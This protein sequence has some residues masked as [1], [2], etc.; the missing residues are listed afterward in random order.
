M[1]IQ[2]IGNNNNKN[3]IG[4]KVELISKDKKQFKEQ[5]PTRGYQ[6]SS[7]PILHFGLG[8]TRTIDTLLV[9]WPDG[10][11][12]FNYHVV[13]N[14]KIII[15]KNDAVSL[16]NFNRKNE[17]SKLFKYIK[18]PN[19][20]LDFTHQENNF[21]DFKKQLLLPHKMSQFGPAMA[22]ADFNEDGR[23]DIFLGGSSGYKSALYFQD[24]NGALIQQKNKVFDK[25]IL[26]EEIDALAFD[27]DGDKD[28]DLYVVS[29]GNEFNP[30][31]TNYQ[32][33]LFINDGKG[34]FT[35]GSDLLPKNTS[36]GSVVKTVDFDNDGDL[37]LFVGTR[38]LPHN[39]PLSQSSFIYKN[40]NGHFEDVTKI[41]APELM[42]SGMV[43]DAVWADVNADKKID[44]IVV[45]E[46]M[47]P[48][49][50]LQDNNGIFTKQPN[51]KLGLSNMSGWWFSIEKNDLD[52]DGDVDFVLGNLG[53]NYKYQA[54]AKHPFKVF[55]K[56]FNN[57][58]SMDIV[59]SYSQNNDY[60]PVRGKQ[61]SSEQIPELKKKFKDYNS[62]AKA[63]VK[64][65]YSD[66][67]IQNALELNAT[68][69]SSYILRNDNGH[70]TPIKL[71]NYAQISSI[72][73]ILIDDFDNDGT[74][75]ILVAG[76]LYV[77]EVETTR[78]DAG[79][80]CII[81]FDKNY[82]NIKTL[83]PY[84]TGLFI[85]GDCKKLGKIKIGEINYLV[86]ALNNSHI[87]IHRYNYNKPNST[88]SI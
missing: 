82:K 15:N 67:G 80:G 40:N 25:Y 55:A 66:L 34:H 53:N 63:D 2:F 68:T 86:S 10:K 70:F 60:Y 21:D 83:M 74:K 38:H 52:G 6:S 44:L 76:N 65:I 48:W 13:T 88:N 22:I 62:F 32:D 78:N 61:C 84:E 72:N 51:N 9:K 58:G 41:I 20:I 35:D 42:S 57:S 54:T 4:S 30:D 75:E 28:L 73:D 85:K 31:N 3:A 29:G 56:D 36:S 5:M 39:Y 14:Q 19:A 64:S 46:W 45:G 17:K 12:S 87:A 59:L 11:I 27:F 49:V 79:Y 7:S 18:N 24:K 37:D 47:E 77:S 43:T 26:H 16:H 33:A 69:F 23:D 1:N 81:D 71:P 8:K 50:M